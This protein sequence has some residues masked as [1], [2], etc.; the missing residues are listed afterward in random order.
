MTELQKIKEQVEE[1]LQSQQANKKFKDVGRVSQTKKERS[2]YKLISGQ[3]LNQLEEDSVMAYNM[4]KKENVWLEVNVEKER[5]NGT[6]SGATYL[7]VKLREA[8]PSRPKDD[9]SKRAI[10][11]LFLE[12]LQKDLEQCFCVAQITALVNKY[13]ELSTE[14]II[15][16]FINPKYLSATENEKIE[17]IEKLKQN[18][19]IRIALL[20]GSNSLFRKILNEVFG[21]RFENIFFNLSDASMLIWKDSIHKEPITEEES[22]IKIKEL[23][24]KKQKF[25]DANYKFISEY[26]EMDENTLKNNMNYKWNINVDLKIIYK[27]DIEKFREFAISYYERKVR[28]E[29]PKFEEKEKLFQPKPND[30]SWVD[31]PK[32]NNEIKKVKSKSINTKVPLSYIKRTGGYKIDSNNAKEIIENFGFNAVNY[33]VYVDDKW[34]KEHTKHFLGAISDLAEVLNIDIKKINQLGKLSI[35]FGAKGTPG[36]LATYFPQTKDINLTKGNGDGSVAHEWGHYFDNVIVELDEKRATNSFASSNESK[37]VEIANVFRK[38]MSFIYHGN[39]EYTPLIPMVF[40]GKK[41]DNPPTYHVKINNSWEQKQL[42]I[43][44]TIEETL[45]QLNGFK[46]VDKNIYSTQLRL[47]GYVIDAFGLDEYYIPMKLNTSYFYHKSA[48]N[49]FQ[50]CFNG[51]NGIETVTKIRTKYWTSSVE[52]FARAWE[53]VIFKKIID[54]GRFSNYLVD[55][56]PMNDIVSESYNSPYPSGKELSYI[57]SLID[58]IVI[59]VKN[60]FNISNFIPN[61]PIREDE[62]IDLQ[63]NLLGKTDKGMVVETDKDGTQEVEFVDGNKIQK[64]MAKETIKDKIISNANLLKGM[65]TH[66]E[67]R[68]WAIKQGFDNRSAFPKFKTALNSIGLDYDQIKTGVHSS[69]KENLEQKITHSVTLYCDAKASR[70]KYGITD[71]DGNV[72]WYGKFFDTDEYAEQSDAEL[73]AAKKAVWL[74]SKVKEAIGADAIE[75]NLIID[76]QWLTY[77][78]HGG[79]KG[80]ALSVLARKYNI[81]LNVEW[82][83]G[84]ENPAD[85]WTT[86]NGFKKWQDNN[87]KDLAMPIS[88]NNSEE[89]DNVKNDDMETKDI[90]KKDVPESIELLDEGMWHGNEVRIIGLDEVGNVIIKELNSER[91][92]KISLESFEKEFSKFPISESDILSSAIQDV[93]T[94][95]EIGHEHKN[96]Y[97]DLDLSE[98]KVLYSIAGRAFKIGNGDPITLLDEIRQS[99]EEMGYVR[100]DDEDNYILSER[101]EDFINSVNNRVETI[102]GIKEKS[103]LFPSDAG[104][105]HEPERVYSDIKSCLLEEGESDST[106]IFEG[107]EFIN[108]VSGSNERWR[109]ISFYKYGIVVEHIPHN[110]LTSKKDKVKLSFKELRQLYLDNDIEIYGI[111]EIKLLDHCLKI[112][113][114]CIDSID[115]KESLDNEKRLHAATKLSYEQKEK[116]K[117]EEQERIERDEQEKREKE[118]RDEEIKKKTINIFQVRLKILKKMYDKAP[119]IKLKTRIKII[120]KMLTKVN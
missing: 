48:Y 83:S 96:K 82:I 104:H 53:T 113:T 57:E 34:S 24:E 4:V 62:Y 55:D 99:L 32:I 46:K 28:I 95:K 12:M 94:I 116:H 80:Y 31:S 81:K 66:T 35:A 87:L 67:L 40:Y 110:K 88:K 6:T 23:K 41:L 9:K 106:Y 21:A 2:A 10:Y 101:G 36:H 74:A 92:H 97:G 30:W 8:I 111:T 112:I 103:D 120:E 63:N 107:K 114:K 70:G 47:F 59:S 79:Q 108:S 38:L 102:R 19:N 56:I 109:I 85:K 65:K 58:D 43:K 61:C 16:L 13:R 33:G 15:G 118:K 37:D 72:V 105:I 45:E 14:K 73:S 117:K 44:N 49:F 26:K 1:R 50:Y 93:L 3:I 115:Y 18:S 5:G 42:E 68:N 76:A 91:E 27:K 64:K 29:L 39:S 84:K 86:E 90:I 11:V 98:A 75:L 20:H 89:N 78:T 100:Y 7:K 52:L 60:K 69:E 71:A 54:R 51:T 22:R 119:T 25:I 77:Q 17:I